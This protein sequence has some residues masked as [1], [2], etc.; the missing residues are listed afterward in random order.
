M[1]SE[2]RNRIV[3]ITL[4]VIALWAV[5][6]VGIIVDVRSQYAHSIYSQANVPDKPVII[7]LG[8]SLKPDKTPSDA[9]VDRLRVGRALYESKKGAKI[10]VTGDD[11]RFHSD[12]VD[13]MKDYLEKSGVTSTDIVV[14]GQ[15]YRT[16]E[17][18]ARAKTQFNI[19]QAIIVTQNFHLP[20]ALYLCNQLGV[21]SVGVSADLNQYRNIVWMTLRDWLASAKAWWDINIWTPKPPV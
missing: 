21:E 14:D 4:A 12:E 15:G 19:D 20:R 3:R 9:L 10:L 6:A 16:Y 1:T 11:G 18:C 2:F 8:A 5:F 17:S 13:A 7:V